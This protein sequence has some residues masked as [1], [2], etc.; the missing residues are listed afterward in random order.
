MTTHYPNGCQSER[1]FHLPSDHA[2][3]HFVMIV[4]KGRGAGI[5]VRMC[6]QHAQAA[7]SRFAGDPDRTVLLSDFHEWERLNTPTVEPASVNDLPPDSRM[8]LAARLIALTESELNSEAP[9]LRKRISDALEYMDEIANPNTHTLNHIRRYL[10]GA[11]EA[12]ET[13]HG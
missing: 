2:A 13:R 3:D 4:Y 10:E 12:Q 1:P 5:P 9:R 6:K 8:A 11:Y 7:V